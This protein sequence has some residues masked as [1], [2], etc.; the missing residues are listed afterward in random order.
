MNCI[1]NVCPECLPKIGAL[2]VPRSKDEYD[3]GGYPEERCIVCGAIR[4]IEEE[5][6]KE[7]CKVRGC[8][9]PGSNQVRLLPLYEGEDNLPQWEPQ[10][11]PE[12][13]YRIRYQNMGDPCTYSIDFPTLAGAERQW[14][15]EIH[16][17]HSY[18]IL[19]CVHKQAEVYTLRSWLSQNGG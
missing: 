3:Q 18:I 13:Q 1:C 6:E 16:K 12:A 4:A 5:E 10:D 19:A 11:P 17:P 15:E 14:E 2:I 7:W 9:L 8:C